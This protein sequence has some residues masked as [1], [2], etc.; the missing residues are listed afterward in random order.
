M[1]QM[2]S[3]QQFGVKDHMSD[4]PAAFTNS[5]YVMPQAP[6]SNRVFQNKEHLTIRDPTMSKV[7]S[8]IDPA[9]L[10]SSA[11]A[12]QMLLRSENT[13]LGGDKSKEQF[14]MRGHLDE[15]EKVLND[16]VTE[17]RYHRQQVGICSAEKDTLGAVLQMNIVKDKNA[18]LNEEYRNREDLKRANE[19]QEVQYEKFNRQLAAIQADHNTENTRIMQLQRRIYDQEGHIGI[20]QQ[21]WEN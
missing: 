3:A 16:M 10:D 21:K 15:I 4:A 7:A 18:V 1:H 19:Q 9:A 13:L 8:T 11:E 17:L 2:N 6:S 20:A 12:M 14:T 5:Q